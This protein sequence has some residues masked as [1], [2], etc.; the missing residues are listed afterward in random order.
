MTVH[1]M[2]VN[3]AQTTVEHHHGQ[4]HSNMY[5]FADHLQHVLQWHSGQTR[6][7]HIQY[8]SAQSARFSIP[9]QRL[10]M[11]LSPKTQY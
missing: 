1:Q 11:S 4:A 2:P 3:L 9:Y 5:S 7:W 8:I 10:A 6:V